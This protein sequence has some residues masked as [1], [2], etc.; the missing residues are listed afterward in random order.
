MI[1][2][3]NK[4]AHRAPHLRKHHIPGPDTIDSL[5]TIGGAYHHEGPFDATLLARNTSFLH[6]PLEAVADSNQEAIRATPRENIQD[7]LERHRPL[8]GIAVVPS[9]MPDKFGRT[10]N[11]EEGTDLMIEG[12][13][14]RWPNVAYL[15]EDL[16]GKGEP[17]YSI[18]KALKEHKQSHRRFV[19]EGGQG[20]EMTSR[21]R[22]GVIDDHADIAG[23][24]RRYVDFEND[25][26]RSNSTGRRVS[27]GIRRTLGSL[28]RKNKSH[29]S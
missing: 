13:Y 3:D 16:K 9:G 7:S 1:K 14:K 25:I 5:D 17:S 26:G 21:P 28:R 15:P 19:S 10:L 8:D 20:I 27:A 12:G 6:S 22:S 29:E 24:Q 18:E 23:G 2:K 11:Y 4:L